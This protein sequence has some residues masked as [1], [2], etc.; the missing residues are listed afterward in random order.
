ML[1]SAVCWDTPGSSPLLH[2]PLLPGLGDVGKSF[3]IENLLKEAPPFRQLPANPVP[4]KLCPSAEQITSTGGPYSTRWA[5][6]VLNPTA[7]QPAHSANRAIFYHTPAA[8]AT[9]KHLFPRVPPYSFM[10]C[11]GSC[12]HLASPTAF[13]KAESVLPLWT[14]DI[15]FRTR[16]GILR[17]AV[18]SEEQRK[19]LEKMFLKQ[20]YISKTDRKKLAVTLELKESQVKIW[21]QNRRMKWRNSKEKE[22]LANGCS[23]EEIL[24]ENTM[25][26]STLNDHSSHT[27]I[28]DTSSTRNTSISTA[29]MSLDDIIMKALV[30]SLCQTEAPT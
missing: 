23:H 5:F 25:A 13:P 18:F 24:Q 8:T 11:G 3:L 15:N 1:P 17:R 30:K 21:F 20:K 12:Q 29:L 6:Q 2:A 9:S 19:E 28:I 7:S 26:N 4:L 22:M 10:C 16:R 27:P 14:Q